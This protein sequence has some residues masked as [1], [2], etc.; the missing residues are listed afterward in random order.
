MNVE[1]ARKHYYDHSGSASASA[2]QLAF[3]GIAVVWILATEH[4]IVEQ[5]ELRFPLLA[6]VFALA[7]DLLQYYVAALLWGGFARYKERRG[8]LEFSGAP[9]WINWP[10]VVAFWGK[11]VL[12]AVGYVVLIFMLWPKLFLADVSSD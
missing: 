1:D 11:G 8:E 4:G 7:F 9:D 6:F 10:G 3:A 2:R 5:P 12:V